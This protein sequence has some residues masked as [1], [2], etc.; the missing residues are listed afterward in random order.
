MKHGIIIIIVGLAFIMQVKG[1]T[2]SLK[3][4]LLYDATTTVNFGME[5]G[6]SNKWTLDISGNYNPWQFNG[7]KKLKHWMVQPEIRYWLCERFY[8]HFIGL[9]LHYAYYN[10]GGI[11]MF[12]LEHHRYQGF[13]YGGGISYGYQWIIGNFWLLEMS[14]GAGYAYGEYGKYRCEEC[15]EKIKDDLF[16]YFGPTKASVS[17]IY[18]IR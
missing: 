10:A 14:V 15:G 16:H 17:L 18:L 6:L 4:N 2:I 3:S 5:T 8:G 11:K 13:L 9:H 7:N 12:G 1:Q